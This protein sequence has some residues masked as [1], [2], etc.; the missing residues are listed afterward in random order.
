MS[1]DLCEAEQIQSPGCIQPP[2][3]LYCM[4][5][6]T[7]ETLAATTNVGEVLPDGKLPDAALD[8]LKRYAVEGE[9]ETGIEF[10]LGE[11]AVAFAHLKD[12]VLLVEVEKLC[13][14]DRIYCH[15]GFE[16]QVAIS[17]LSD[18]LTL[19]EAA[20]LAADAIRKLTGMERVLIY[21]FDRYANGDV[22]AESKTPDWAESFDGF[23]FPSAD[24]PT[25]ARS[26]YLTSPARFTACRDYE[27]IEIRPALNPLTGK[28]FDIGRCR[29]R[30]LSPI[31]RRY[32]ENL[33]IDG[34]FSLSIVTQGRLWG[35]VVGHHRR[36]HRVPIPARQQAVALT[37]ALA[38]SIS[39]MEVVEER[40]GHERDHIIH[41]QLLEQ[42]ATAGD[43]LPLL[44]GGQT[45]LTDL[46]FGSI[47]AAVGSWTEND[48]DGQ[49]TIQTVGFVPEERAIF[50]L[51]RCC[52]EHMINGLF[53]T[54]CIAKLAPEFI[55]HAQIASGVLAITIGQPTNQII[56]WFLPEVIGTRVWGGAT[57][58]QVKKAKSDG[59]YLP[60][61][62]FERWAEEKRGYSR[63]WLGRELELGR[64]L[65]RTLNNVILV[66]KGAIH[67]LEGRVAEK[68]RAIETY[69][70]SVES[71]NQNLEQFAWIASHDLRE[72]LRMISSY[73]SLIERRYHGLFDTEA[74][75][76]FGFA[77][78]GAKRLDAMILDLLEFSRIGREDKD[79]AP[80]PLAD[81]IAEVMDNLAVATAESGAE[82]RIDAEMPVVFG[83]YGELV[84]L[85]QNLLG[86]A[87]KYRHPD[88]SPVVRVS[89]RPRLDE[90]E[91]AVADN[92][93][94][95]EESHFDR[96]FRVFQR[97]HTREKYDGTGIGLSI[98]K[99]IVEHHGGRLWVESEFGNGTTFL[100]TIPIRQMGPG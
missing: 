42:I 44:V 58:E 99:K 59:D 64:A 61:R 56:L 9:G 1:A 72:P 38:V 87:I 55:S 78:E 63:P 11:E 33:G 85:F 86:N 7:L 81:V 29:S 47:G 41:G 50:D 93:I 8:R 95:I 36:P 19:E 54:D 5:P 57:P 96:I 26:L 4:H 67:T 37:G 21:R 25:Q 97:L 43:F 16:L 27:P 32:Q 77:R 49:L 3:A 83:G 22:V 51:I 10:M 100:F 45:K 48:D 65:Q 13:P 89:C 91:I 46:F 15:G 2:F 75:E 79:L 71:S 18:I 80:V 6:A 73:L 40:I 62:S 70:R 94:G 53:A 98:S 68:T 84:R 14:E 76:F 20:G 17:A 31:H 35:L 39:A 74:R 92:G 90:W 30:S 23:S 82:I 12:N 69:A 34:A 60:R 24:I 66:Q 28:P 88:R 52:R